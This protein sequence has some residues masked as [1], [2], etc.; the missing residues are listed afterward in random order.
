MIFLSHIRSKGE[1]FT[2]NIKFVILYNT[3]KISYYCTV[4][5]KIPIEQRSSVIYQITCPSCLKRYVGKTDRFFHIKMNK[6]GRKLDQP[7]HRDLKIAVIF[8]N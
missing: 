7:M 2:T 3:R 4:K 1:D 6:H 5:Y 8:K